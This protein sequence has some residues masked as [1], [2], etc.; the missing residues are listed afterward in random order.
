MTDSNAGT[1]ALSDKT[2][3]AIPEAAR[4]VLQL[5][6]EKSRFLI[7]GHIRPDGDCLGSCL[8]LAQIL[9][10]LGKISQVYTAG[11]LPAMY[12]YLNGFD[13]VVTDLPSADQFEAILCVDTADAG[14]VFPGYEPSGLMAVVDHHISN[15]HFGKLNWVDS[16]AAAASEMIYQIGEW[17]DAEI[18]PAIATALYTGIATDTGGF[19]FSNTTA[20]T[21]QIA[22]DL[23][24]R[25]ANAADIAERVWGSRSPAAVKIAALVMSTINYEFDGRFAWNEVTQKMMSEA[26]GDESELEG[27]SGEM[28]AIEG[29]EIAVLFSETADGECRIGFRSKSQVNVSTLA[30]LLGGGG[31]KSASGATIRENYLLARQ[32]ALDVIRNYLKEQWATSQS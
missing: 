32:R 1:A 31:H 16:G 2:T 24:S 15:T 7:I 3:P 27:V 8:G 18:T 6:H 21:F 25:G 22:A 20:R 9:T 14:R 17:L 11:P 4:A 12:S 23:V 19:R 30:R 26:G 10:Q 28:R 5:I 29:V 13:D